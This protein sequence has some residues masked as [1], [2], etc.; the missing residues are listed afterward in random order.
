MLRD[1]RYELFQKYAPPLPNDTTLL[2]EAFYTLFPIGHFCSHLGTRAKSLER[3]NHK[4]HKPGFP[5][6]DCRCC[7]SGRFRNIFG[8]YIDSMNLDI[9]TGLT[10]TKIKNRAYRFM[11]RGRRLYFGIGRHPRYDR[12][13]YLAI[14][15]TWRFDLETQKLTLL[16]EK[17][18]GAYS[19]LV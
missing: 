11:R 6:W 12:E 13:Y 4:R 3:C 19:S 16:K 9:P 18:T 17:D 1:S 14:E 15:Q 5:R 10:G 8:R 2:E 7:Q